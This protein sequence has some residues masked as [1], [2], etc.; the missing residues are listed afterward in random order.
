[1]PNVA[2][3]DATV[4]FPATLADTL[5]RAADAELY[6]PCWTD[7]VLADLRHS[8]AHRGGLPVEAVERRASGIRESFPAALVNGSGIREEH[9][10]CHPRGKANLAA[11]LRGHCDTLV[12]F[13]ERDFLGQRA[14]GIRVVDPDTFLVD[15]VDQYQPAVLR[16]LELQLH[17]SRPGASW[18]DL[19]G[20]LDP[21][22]PVFASEI[23]RAL[24]KWPSWLDHTDTAPRR[25]V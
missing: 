15:L 14:A 10:E 11:A 7:A 22:V 13:D 17:V 18:N 12:T 3:L 2:F 16:A 8:L 21:W 23:R 25:A 5:L 24:A 6:A 9:L 20:T 1:M 4:L 19:L